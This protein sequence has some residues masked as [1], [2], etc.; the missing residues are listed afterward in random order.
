MYEMLCGRPPFTDAQQLHGLRKLLPQQAQFPPAISSPAC[1]LITELLQPHID[2]RLGTGD[3]G[4]L[5]VR[6]HSFFVSMDWARLLAK[7]EEPPF[8]P[9]SVSAVDAIDIDAV[10]QPLL[11]TDSGRE[12]YTQ[13]VQQGTRRQRSAYPVDHDTKLQVPIIL[14]KVFVGGIGSLTQQQLRESFE[15]FG[16]VESTQAMTTREGRPRG[17][18]FVVFMQMATAEEVIS[19]CTVRA[20]GRSVEVKRC[21]QQSKSRPC[22]PPFP[23]PSPSPAGGPIQQPQ[24]QEVQAPV[25]HQTPP[26]RKV[27]AQRSPSRR[28]SGSAQQ[29]SGEPATG[30]KP[31]RA[32]P[33][34]KKPT[35]ANKAAHVHTASTHK[36]AKSKRR[37]NPPVDIQAARVDAND[38]AV[39]PSQ[40]A[41]GSMLSPELMHKLALMMVPIIVG[42]MSFTFAAELSAPFAVWYQR[43]D[44]FSKEINDCA[45]TPCAN[46]GT[47]IS[48][49]QSQVGL[50]IECRCSPGWE[51]PLCSIDTNE[52]AALPCPPGSTCYDSTSDPA[53]PTGKHVCACDSKWRDC[54]GVLV[55]GMDDVCVHGGDNGTDD[56]E[57]ASHPC[58]NG[59]TCYDSTHSSDVRMGDYLCK[60]PK[61]RHG[62]NCE[63]LIL[64]VGE[65]HY[66][67]LSSGDLGD[68]MSHLQSSVVLTEEDQLANMLSVSSSSLSTRPHACASV[69]CQHNATC[70][71]KDEGYT[72]RCGE[73]WEGPNCER[74]MHTAAAECPYLS[75]VQLAQD[76]LGGQRKL[77]SPCSFGPCIVHSDGC[78]CLLYQWHYCSQPGLQELD[79]FCASLLDGMQEP[80]AKRWLK[81]CMA[82][83]RVLRSRGEG[84]SSSSSVA[85]LNGLDLARA[86][87]AE[88]DET[89]GGADEVEVVF[90]EPGSLGLKF[91]QHA[92]TGAVVVMEVVPATQA[93]RHPQLVPGLT[94]CAVGE[95]QVGGRGYKEAIRLLKKASA[96]RPLVCRFALAAA[97]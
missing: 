79:P 49:R 12:A 77:D 29:T 1:A 35:V 68:P 34:E 89:V 45:S 20:F 48:V 80:E 27:T 92:E 37:K 43:V 93:A 44:E 96:T 58:T 95:T 70:Q 21:Q 4:S 81:T 63:F 67:G 25:Q 66:L 9:N 84:S 65:Q 16:P 36:A 52:C 97:E 82:E 88:Y 47:C 5:A 59:G 56:A 26:P 2:L 64:N 73:F 31:P 30:V 69:P 22:A 7:Q 13:P 33:K 6:G 15:R 28:L 50:S 87:R 85:A 32:A 19:I 54:D 23:S 42:L 60:C 24:A 57:C 53:L 8:I 86:P 62:A 55:C 41:R 17:F 61:E 91:V 10:S 51:G 83:V 75:A 14:R 39:E 72:C 78:E 3:R 38:E 90:T 18:G 46:G 11:G 74:Q 94:L 71:P 40:T 76:G